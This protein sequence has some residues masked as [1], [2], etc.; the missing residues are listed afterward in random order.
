MGAMPMIR[1]PATRAA[2]V[3]ASCVAIAIVVLATRTARA[4]DA[5]EGDASKPATA[6][7]SR[8]VMSVGAG[9]ERL[10]LFGVSISG[11]E[12]EAVIGGK[13]G[14]VVL[15]ADLEGFS[16]STEYGLSTTM[17]SGGM[18]LEGAFDRVRI[19]GGLRVGMLDVHR[20]SGGRNLEGSNAGCFVRGSFD[21]VRFDS[22]RGALFLALKLSADS[23]G[24][25]LYGLTMG[26]G[27]RF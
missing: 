23:V 20:A 4:D 9:Y 18:L 1:S 24:G 21:V 22:D 13:I 3:A 2:K 15:A 14:D 27:M 26:G 16:G 5:P 19:G 11:A 7:P 10:S 25:A 17:F 6:Q 8:F 12:V